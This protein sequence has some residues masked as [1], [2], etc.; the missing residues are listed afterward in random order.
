M[1]QWG[2]LMQKVFNRTNKYRLNDL[3]INYLGYYTDN[4]AYYYYNT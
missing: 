2:S 3:T 1:V 4:G